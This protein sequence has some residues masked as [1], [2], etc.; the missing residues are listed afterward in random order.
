MTINN[1][2]NAGLGYITIDAKSRPSP[3]LAVTSITKSGMI[4]VPSFPDVSVTLKVT[5]VYVPYSNSLNVIV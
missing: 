2:L 4:K 3:E 1:L 5:P